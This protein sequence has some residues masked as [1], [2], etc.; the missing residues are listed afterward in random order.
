VVTSS[1]DLDKTVSISVTPGSGT[2]AVYEGEVE[3]F[4]VTVS[5]VL[6]LMQLS[7]GGT[8]TGIS[9]FTTVDSVTVTPVGGVPPFLYTWRI[10]NIEGA[11]SPRA[12]SPNSQITY[13]SAAARRYDPFSF[14]AICTIFDSLG[15]TQD[16]PEITIR[17]S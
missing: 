10:V 16:S 1:A 14:G 13:F 17:K 12:L 9:G 2:G 11:F 8:G 6:L 3:P 15:R 4:L 5:T 7:S